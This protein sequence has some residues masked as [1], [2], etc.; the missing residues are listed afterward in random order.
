MHTSL[1]GTFNFTPNG[2][3]VKT[4]DAVTRRKLTDIARKTTIW[5]VLKGKTQISMGSL[6]RFL[7]LHIY[8][9]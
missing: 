4:S 5:H 3:T 7:P 1:L 2:G 6:I 9:A 8:N